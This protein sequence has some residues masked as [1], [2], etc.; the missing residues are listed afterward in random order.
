MRIARILA[1]FAALAL[2]AAVQAAAQDRPVISNRTGEDA[3]ILKSGF[4]LI[5]RPKDQRLLAFYDADGKIGF[6]RNNSSPSIYI[7]P[8]FDDC[9]L[10][11][12]RLL[13]VAKDGKWG[14]VDLMLQ[15]SSG[16]EQPVIPCVYDMVYSCDD[17]HVW[18]EKD[19]KRVLLD[20]RD[21]AT[22][23]W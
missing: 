7:E 6:L 9:E 22:N 21:F 18:A 3:Y 2:L 15:L 19:G 12:K 14:A 16:K 13:P 17:E 11:D 8:Y 10:T 5:S 20:I 23:K 1:A 4:S